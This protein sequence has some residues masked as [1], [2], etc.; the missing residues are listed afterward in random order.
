MKEKIPCVYHPPKECPHSCDVHFNTSILIQAFS[1][2]LGIP[3]K[4][5]ADTL[6]NATAEETY[7]IENRGIL[8]LSML[9][10]KSGCFY[11]AKN[12]KTH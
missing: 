8:I 11:D 3:E 4:D 1:R 12:P 5:I 10:E 9:G 6:F 2:R 7:E